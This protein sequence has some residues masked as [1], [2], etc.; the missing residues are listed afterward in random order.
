V[1]TSTR[2]AF[3]SGDHFMPDEAGYAAWIERCEG[4]D[5]VQVVDEAIDVFDLRDYGKWE[6]SPVLVRE[7]SEVEARIAGHECPWY[8]ECT[9]RAKGAQPFWRITLVTDD[10]EAQGG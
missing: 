3:D 8:I 9:P 2:E 7:E 10:K 4:D 6:A 5:P 1:A